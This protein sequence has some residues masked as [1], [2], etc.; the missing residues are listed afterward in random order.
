M[1]SRSPMKTAA[2]KSPKPSKCKICRGEYIKR[3]MSHKACKPE[4]AAEFVRLD[5]EKK[6]RQAM[7]ADRVVD[8]AKREAMK[9]YAKLIAEAQTAFNAFIRARDILA[10]HG[11]IDC[12]KP[13]E[14]DR[15]G[16]SVDAGHY[17][18]RGSAPHLRF[19]ERNVFA[20]RKNCNRPGGA[21]REAVRAGVE[22][23]IG[24]EALEALEADQTTQKWT[25]DDLRTI[26]VLYQR[27]KKDLLASKSD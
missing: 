22:K 12:G 11:C 4:C 27:K 10:G 20:Q 16:G 19:D 25:H 23:R 6:A 9:P 13:F 26:R 7:R 2:K 24:I 21:T 8:R 18:S 1:I 14:P 17:L 3:S 5:N 15:P